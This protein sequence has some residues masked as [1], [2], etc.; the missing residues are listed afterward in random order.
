MCS[1][2]HDSSTGS[3]VSYKTSKTRARLPWGAAAAWVCVSWSCNVVEDEQ[4]YLKTC[5][6]K[7]EENKKV[8][9]VVIKEMKKK[10]MV[11]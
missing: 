7:R 4:N 9:A 3:N 5:V 8:E 1:L 2:F 10:N 11:H 6:V